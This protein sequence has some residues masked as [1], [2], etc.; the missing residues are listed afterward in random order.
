MA[1]AFLQGLISIPKENTI[2]K[3]LAQDTNSIGFVDIEN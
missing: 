2:K 3:Y 1:E